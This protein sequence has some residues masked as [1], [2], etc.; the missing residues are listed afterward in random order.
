MTEELGG[1][2]LAAMEKYARQINQAALNPAIVIAKKLY[3]DKYE[4]MIAAQ[5][6]VDKLEKPYKEKADELEEYII[7]QVLEL[8]LSAK[9][10]GV[11][12]K[13]RKG[14]ERVTW[15][16]KEMTSLCMKNPALLDL[17][18]SARKVTDVDPSVKISYTPEVVESETQSEETPF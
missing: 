10:A 4:E 8:G 12:A 16:N 17:L 7:A 3:D 6:V 5:E 15:N 9:H 13:H 1:N 14:Y 18:A 2:L 11:E